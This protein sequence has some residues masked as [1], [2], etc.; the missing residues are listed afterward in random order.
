MP[1]TDIIYKAMQTHRE[2]N[3]SLKQISASNAGRI[4]NIELYLTSKPLDVEMLRYS[5]LHEISRSLSSTMHR[6]GID[7][8]YLG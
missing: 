7:P 1:S 8:S 4:P 5:I 3:A 2:I 6:M